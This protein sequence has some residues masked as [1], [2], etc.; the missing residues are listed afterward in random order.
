MQLM[1]LLRKALPALAVACTVIVSLSAVQ[2]AAPAPARRFK[3]AAVAF[4]PAWGDL[5][6]NI[7][8]MVAGLEDVAKQGVR[9]AV[10]PEQATVGYIFDDFA[11]VEPYLDTVPGK[12]TAAISKVTRAHRM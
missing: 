9:L 12:A 7:S 8:R 2:A 10:L 4:D 6:G 3:V 11:M 5:D 1:S